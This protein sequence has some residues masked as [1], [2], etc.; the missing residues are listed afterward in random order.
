MRELRAQATS[1]GHAS[2]PAHDERVTRP[3]EMRADLLAPLE[4]CVARPRPRRAVVGIHDLGSPLIEAAV[5]LGQL[6]LHLVGER[7]AVLHRELVE[8]AGDR[9]LHAGAVVAPDPQDQ[10]VV[11]LPELLDRVQHPTDVVVGVLGVPR[12]DL[13]LARVELLE[14]VRHRVPRGERRVARGELCVGRDHSQPLLAS[15]RL[16]P[17]L[18]PALVELPLVLVGPGLRDVV[19]RVAAAGRVVDEERL[20]GILRTNAVEP[21]DRLIGHRVG[22]V[23]RIALVVVALVDPDDLLVLGE[24]RVPLA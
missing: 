6:Q 9:A 19:W 21:L 7:D 23:V 13:H 5:P 22:E 16:L 15:E 4:R 12:V 8:R 3:S 2:R 20:R 14:L 1:V 18:V 24:A 11:E 10:G 17:K